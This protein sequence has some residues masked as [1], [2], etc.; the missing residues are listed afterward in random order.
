MGGEDVC[1]CHPYSSGL[2][3]EICTDV[4]RAGRMGGW[5]EQAHGRKQDRLQSALMEEG[6][7]MPARGSG[8]MQGCLERMSSLADKLINLS[9]EVALS[10]GSQSAA[11]DS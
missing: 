9:I 1:V 8:C 7:T 6:E 10:R 11:F 5:E 3:E 2:Y 4:V